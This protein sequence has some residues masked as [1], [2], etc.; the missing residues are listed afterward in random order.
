MATFNTTT[1]RPHFRFGSSLSLIT[2][3]N[4]AAD[5]QGINCAVLVGVAIHYIVDRHITVIS[6]KSRARLHPGINCGRTLLLWTSRC[7]HSHSR[8]TPIHCHSS[9]TFIHH[10]HKKLKITLK[11]IKTKN[12]RK[13]GQTSKI[14]KSASHTP[15]STIYL[16]PSTI[17]H[18]PHTA[19]PIDARQYATA[20]L[21]SSC[22]CLRDSRGSHRASVYD[23]NTTTRLAGSIAVHHIH[24]PTHPQPSTHLTRSGS[25]SLFSPPPL[26]FQRIQLN[27]KKSTL[28]N[29]KPKTTKQVKTKNQLNQ[30]RK[31]RPHTHI[32]QPLPG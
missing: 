32:R 2:S 14:F 15:T 4:R 29:G 27:N 13:N 22:L 18:H 24:H 25:E 5:L 20:A 6:V 7:S 11:M 1:T 30:Q 31:I 10:G 23:Y 9:S 3:D 12:H 19:P 28:N 8:P 17:I 21:P 26:H 16:S